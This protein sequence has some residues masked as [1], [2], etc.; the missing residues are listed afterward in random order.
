MPVDCYRVVAVQ[1]SSDGAVEVETRSLAPWNTDIGELLALAAPSARRLGRGGRY[2]V[3]APERDAALALL[4]SHLEPVV[5]AMGT[6]CDV[7]VCLDFHQ[8]PRDGAP[9]DRWERTEPGELVYRAKYRGGRAGLLSRALARAAGAESWR[10]GRALRSM[11]AEYV[12]A[13]PVLR[14]VTGVAAMPGSER[15]AGAA[16]HLAGIARGVADR[17]GAPLVGLRRA[18]G[19]RRCGRSSRRPVRHAARIRAAQA[20]VPPR[21]LRG[22]GSGS[23]RPVHAP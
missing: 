4:G 14:R 22:G 1:P 8:A 18:R 6:G 5:T 19:V 7:A 16:P 23:G 15:G 13:H 10:A 17:F 9:P 20:P 3:D 21:Y 11:V 12:G 2:A